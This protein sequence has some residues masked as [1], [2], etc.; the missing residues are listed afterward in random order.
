MGRGRR[1]AYPGAFFHCINRGNQRE[2]IYRDEEDYQFML[3]SLGTVST[4]YGARIH[5]YC[6]IPNHFHLLIQQP[7]IGISTLMRS[8]TT[9]YAL[10]FNQKYGKV[11]HVFQGRFRGILCDQRQYLLELIRYVH[12]NPVRAGLVEHPQDW[13]W[14]SLAAYLG[15][16]RREWLYQE[17]VLGLFGTQ[18]RRNLL[19][20]LSQAPDLSEKIVYPRA[21]FPV[22]GEQ[23]FVNEV[24]RQGEPRRRQPRVH[25]G[26]RLSLPKLARL[27]SRAA[28]VAGDELFTPHKG[29]RPISLLRDQIIYAATRLMYYPS[30]EVARFLGVTPAAVTLSDRRFSERARLNPRLTD[31]LVRLLLENT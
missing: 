19:E 11:G 13:K 28:G 4:R 18:P 31:G 6:L 2:R 10:Y 22:M 26:R 8:L 7:E 21:S 24:V 23:S 3:E 12:L 29:S 1:I 14:S 15:L 5:G 30:S 9:R 16:V 27:F 17:A 20:F 25:A